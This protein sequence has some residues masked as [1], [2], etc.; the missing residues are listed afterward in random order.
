MNSK[1]KSSRQM[2]LAVELTPED[3]ALTHGGGLPPLPGGPKPSE[4]H[5]T[6]A[7]RK[8]IE[9]AIKA[10]ALAVYNAGKKVVHFIGSLF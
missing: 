7:Q 8:A 5:L 10:A 6:D 2:S 9:D 4:I 1:T 3:L